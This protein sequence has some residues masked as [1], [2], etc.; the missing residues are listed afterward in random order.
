MDTHS[1]EGVV[2]EE[3]FQASGNPLT[4]GLTG[5][6]GISD[7]SITGRGQTEKKRIPQ[8]TCLNCNSLG[9]NSPDTCDH[10]QGAGEARVACLGEELGLNALRT[11][12]RS[13][14]ETATQTVG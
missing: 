11:V 8:N 5:S 12:R 1:G 13:E 3:T 7:G 6:F 2:K 9:R 4:S 10:C 14:C